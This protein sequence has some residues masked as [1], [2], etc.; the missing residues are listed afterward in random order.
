MSTA[1]LHSTADRILSSFHVE[2]LSGGATILRRDLQDGTT[3]LVGDG[4]L[5]HEIGRYA[6]YGVDSV[7]LLVPT[8]EYD[9]DP[10]CEPVV[11]V[12]AA[13]ADDV[14]RELLHYAPELFTR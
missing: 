6:P 4:N 7:V 9:A 3:V 13:T 14:V 5:G 11:T 2:R 10:S 12:Y 8:T 1:K